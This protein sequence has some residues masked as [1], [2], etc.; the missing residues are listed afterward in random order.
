V[1]EL[2]KLSG[3]VWRDAVAQFGF[4]LRI[5]RSHF[6]NTLKYIGLGIIQIIAVGLGSDI[7]EIREFDGTKPI[8]S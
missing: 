3:H 6:S 8:L 1:F 4:P 7:G 5:A 2:V